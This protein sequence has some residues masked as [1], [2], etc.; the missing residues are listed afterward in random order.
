MSS[1]G[2]VPMEPLHR[3]VV[4]LA[5]GTA[6]VAVTAAIA[7]S[8]PPASHGADAVSDVV[9]ASPAPMSAM[10]AEPRHAPLFEAASTSL[11]DTPEP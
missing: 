6:A 2:P 9:L 10:P 5:I 11:S 3:L 4:K 8:D 7:V 1:L